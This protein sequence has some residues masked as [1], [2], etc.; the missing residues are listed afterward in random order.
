MQFEYLRFSSSGIS[1]NWNS[2]AHNSY[3]TSQ[4]G[5]SYSNNTINL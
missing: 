4:T 1:S 2:D 5:K 3:N